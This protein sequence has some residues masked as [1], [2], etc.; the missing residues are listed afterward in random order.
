M[1]A[2]EVFLS[3]NIKSITERLIAPYQEPEHH[4]AME[5]LW[6]QSQRMSLAMFLYMQR[7]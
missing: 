7:D 2:S 1:G 4:C 3:I 6:C 5:L